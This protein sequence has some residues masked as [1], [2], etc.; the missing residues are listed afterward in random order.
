L[1]VKKVFKPVKLLAVSIRSETMLTWRF[2]AD[3]WLALVGFELLMFW[4]CSPWSVVLLSTA[5]G[6]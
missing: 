1:A 3:F 5:L 4:K 2:P 6:E